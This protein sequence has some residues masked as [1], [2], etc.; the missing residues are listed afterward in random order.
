M[1]RRLHLALAWGILFGAVVL[2]AACGSTAV[3]TPPPTNSPTNTPPPQPSHTPT[4]QPSNTPTAVPPTAVPPTAVPPTAVP[5]TTTAT[6]E[7]TAT[8][9]PV[10]SISVP[11]VWLEPVGAALAQDES[12]WVWQPVRADD[13]TANAAP[14][15]LMNN[16]EGVLVARE[17][18]VLVVPFNH[19]WT[20]ANLTEAQAIIT[21]GHALAK[22]MPWSAM[23]PTQRPLL[24]NGL[25]PDDPDYPL[26]DSWS[27]VGQAGYET[28]VTQLAAIL[29]PV[30][31]PLP[32]I[33]L[34]AVGDVNLDR[35]LGNAISQGYIDFP[36]ANVAPFFHAADLT[37][38]NL[39]TALGDIGEPQPKNYTFQSPPASAQS[40]ANA[41]F[42]VLS[43][44]NNHALDYGPESLL[45]GLDLL[46]EQGVAVVGAG[47]NAAAARA[48]FITEANGLKVAFL[49]YVHVPVEVTSHF[50]T[51]SWTATA[52]TPGLAWAVPAEIAEDVTAVR[53]QADLVVVILH[54]GYEY[55]IPPSEEQKA[56][57]YAAID[58]GADLVIGH[59][60]H[61][62]QGVQFYKNGVIAF[63]L[64]NF[65][66]N[67]DGEPNSIILNVWLDANGVRQLEFIP[68]IIQFGG[69]PRLADPEE[70]G[71]IRQQIYDRS[72][73]FPLP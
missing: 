39:E 72:R 71:V 21:N 22:A 52:D 1:S 42:D 55:V 5:P 34:A 45:Q 36:F 18:L 6:P 62:L 57:A 24:I 27:L 7:P 64:G 69:Q 26:W 16:A 20:Y 17:P 12:D 46:A 65:A 54:S 44:A 50:D 29:Q 48:P 33:K 31:A 37:V 68:T 49:G 3:P 30:L 14:I 40:L 60:A 32:V 41:G 70:A 67:I 51:A 56:A 25:P 73:A 53:P 47:V 59:H 61:I 15:A 8:P 9:K 10:V 66:F 19:S 28:A 58:A 2:L 63:G 35:S 43:L 38:G 23:R 11:G 4:I 13:P